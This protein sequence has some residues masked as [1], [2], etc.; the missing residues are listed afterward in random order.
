MNAATGSQPTP[1][2]DDALVDKALLEEESFTFDC[3]RL[4]DKLAKILETVVAFANSDGGVIALGLEDP[5]K[6]QGRQ[7]VYG[8]QENLMNWDELRRLMLSRITE[9][10]LLACKA[11]EVGCT[12]RDGTIGS[13]VFLRIE[14]STRIH[15]IVD[16]GTFRRLDKGNKQLTAPE[17]NELSFARGTIT[18]ES[19]LE[20]VDFDL[21]DTDYWRAY[22]RQRRLTRP[23][24]EALLHVGLAKPARDGRVLPMRAAVL[25]FAEEPGGLLGSK[26][27]V[28]IFH[29]RGNKVQTDPNTN[30]LRPPATIS[31]P[32]IR[33]IQ[34]ATESVV[35][36]LASGIQMGPLGFEIVHRYPLRVI[37]E[38]ITN[39][40]I[41]RDYHVVADIHVRIFS[42]R[43]ELESPGLFAGP[44]TP[45]NIGR[46][47]AYNRNPIL[48]SHLREFPDP[49]NLDAGE[50]VRMMFGTMRET[51]LYPPLYLTQPQI[52]R[53]AVLVHL[54]NENRPSLWEQV[55]EYID[56]NGSIGNTEVRQLV[57]SGD[58]LA[59]SKQLQKWVARG[60]LSVLNPNAAK[61]LRR[62]TKPDM[63]LA[64]TLLAELGKP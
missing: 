37:K 30:L 64:Q 9:S 14:K 15:S 49:P 33:Q 55:S 62:Y 26:A 60:Q 34:D 63:P 59:A 1:P 24:H 43:I 50:G 42:D 12:L 19:Q 16:D 57:G 31:G 52:E 21:L 11:H 7:R 54:L 18:A 35:R 22:A 32:V 20:S 13:V 2:L 27:A 25:L 6:A 4:K 5:D 46:V 51:G 53:Q 28:R 17:I 10:G 56:R 47:G 38:A 29:Y 44:I 23:I 39:A 41:H 3:K 36:E 58:V 8:I 61:R 45:A 40:V 48:V